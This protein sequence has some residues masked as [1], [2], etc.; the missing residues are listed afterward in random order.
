M[1]AWPCRNITCTAVSAKRDA[2]ELDHALGD[3]A[4]AAVVDQRDV[5]GPQ[6]PRIL[7]GLDRNAKR[8]Q[9]ALEQRADPADR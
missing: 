3:A 4:I 7:R 5:N 9:R 6:D 8:V 1:F 2:A